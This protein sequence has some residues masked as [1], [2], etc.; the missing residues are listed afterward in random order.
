MATACVL[1]GRLYVIGGAG[2]NTVQV[3]EMTEENGL[4]WSR[5]AGLPANRFGA[6]CAVHDGRIWVIGGCVGEDEV[7]TA[8]VVIYDAEADAW[9][10]GP[11]L[12]AACIGCIAAAMDGGIFVGGSAG[13]FQYTNAEWRRVPG[14][15]KSGAVC[16][17]LLLG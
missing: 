3:L 1:N 2:S 8:S 16:G 11:P 9:G 12:P 17:S 15:R 7:P 14:D 5:K 13:L 4:S 10:T 6:A